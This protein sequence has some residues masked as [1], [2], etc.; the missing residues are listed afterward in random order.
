MSEPARVR[1]RDPER[2]TRILAAAADLVAHKGF[3][4]VSIAEIGA[5]AGITGSGIYRHFESKSAVLVAL[6]DR[7]IDELLRDENEIVSTTPNLTSALDRLIAGQVQFV[8]GDRELAQVYYNEINNLPDEDRRRLRRKQRLYLEEWVH[9]VNEQRP[10]LNDTEART[11]VHTVIG[12]IQST[13][14]HNTGL[15]EDRLRVLLTSAA[16]AILGITD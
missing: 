14:F 6:F 8:V 4:A 2:K 10:D 15:A 13:L 1:T 5:A 7:V 9:L 12:A 16:R 11:V 3:H